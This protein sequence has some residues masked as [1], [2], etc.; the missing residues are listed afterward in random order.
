VGRGSVAVVLVLV[1]VPGTVPDLLP[2]VYRSSQL[3]ATGSR[4]SNH[5]FTV[6]TCQALVQAKGL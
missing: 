1:L 2:V 3:P 6:V 4:G 5:T